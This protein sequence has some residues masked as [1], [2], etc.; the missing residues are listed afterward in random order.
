MGIPYFFYNI[1][2]KYPSISISQLPHIHLFCLD[3]NGIVH[4]IAHKTILIDNN[5][6]NMFNSLWEYTLSLISP[7]DTS[8]I[9]F[10]GVA[11]I[12]KILQQRKRR[13]LKDS[14]DI[15]D[16]NNITC[17]TP[18]MDRL[19]DFVKNKCSLHHIE[20][21][22]TEHNGEGEHKIFEKIGSID[23]NILIHGLDADLIILS[24]ISLKNIYLYRENN[25]KIEY[26]SIPELRKSI[27]IEWKD[28]F[29]K[30]ENENDAIYS[31]CVACS[32][33]GNDFLPHLITINLK[34]NGMEK[35]K[36]AFKKQ[37]PLVINGEIQSNVLAEILRILSLTEDKDLISELKKYNIHNF[38]VDTK[39]RKH[40]YN[41]I[42]FL[43]NTNQAC[44][45]FLDGIFWTF[46][47]YIKSSP[48]DHAWYYPYYDAPSL[49]D[50]ANFSFTYKYSPLNTLQNFISN[51]IQLLLVIPKK[52]YKILH[53]KLHKYYIDDNCGLTHLYPSKCKII[54]FLKKHDWQYIPCLP[55]IDISFLQNLIN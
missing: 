16:T 30:Y 15:W 14:D 27:L 50:L 3:Y 55:L 25:E 11:P 49:K 2:K 17:G 23:G 41:N 36:D 28:I 45:S 35:I 10:D 1:I 39:W 42:I 19:N 40:Y 32:L 4:P 48:I 38:H 21:S 44:K 18:F 7:F 53:Q 51:D 9:A 43:N 5:E 37:D 34:N 29:E 24:L 22:G 12:A 47:Y 20:F 6:T 31:Y 13:F 46:N 33:L 54:T 8:F 52:S 26:I